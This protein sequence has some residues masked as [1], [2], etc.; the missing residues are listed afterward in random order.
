MSRLRESSDG[1][2][3]LRFIPRTLDDSLRSPLV[4]D[5]VEIRIC[6]CEYEVED[7]IPPGT[8]EGEGVSH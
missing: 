1:T 5:R 6:H 7:E 2:N 3:H 4:S 8:N